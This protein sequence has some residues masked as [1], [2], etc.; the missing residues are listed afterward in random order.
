MCGV[1]I[2]GISLGS[3]GVSLI[4]TSLMR[5]Q[6]SREFVRSPAGGIGP[7]TNAEGV[8][9]AWLLLTQH[10]EHLKGPV[11]VSLEFAKMLVG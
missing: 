11:R 7:V 10:E 4:P 2:D 1:T 3:D 6:R 8:L 9:A 5:K